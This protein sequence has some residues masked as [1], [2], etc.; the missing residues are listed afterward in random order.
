REARYRLLVQCAREAGASHLV[1]AH[2]L[3]DQAET[4]L[5]R[6]ARGSGLAGLAGMRAE[7]DREGI[8]HVRP[9][10][11]WPKASLLTLCREQGWAF[12]GD[13]SNEDAR[14][15]RVRWRRIMPLLAEEGLT[16]ERLA[17]LGERAF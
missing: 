9:L 12:V 8:C 17:R 5:M 6:M 11:E 16:A 15:A 14:F 2:T 4:I 1:T 10:L 7:T 3:D 13:P